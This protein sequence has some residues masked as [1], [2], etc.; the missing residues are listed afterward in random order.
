VDQ[1]LVRDR[2][3]ERCS[4]QAA[5]LYLF[6]V[7]V[8][9]CQGL[10]YYSDSSITKR[11]SMEESALEQARRNLIRLD[12]I[13]YRKPLYQVLALP[14]DPRPIS[15]ARVAT[16]LSGSACAGTA[17]RCNAQAVRPLAI[18]Q[19]FKQIMGGAHD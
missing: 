11:L 17:D 7:I 14:A 4:H 3:L 19:I 6:L 12:L 5:A 18:G 9:D 13:A 1:R 10:S 2:Y 15:T 8:A 16:N